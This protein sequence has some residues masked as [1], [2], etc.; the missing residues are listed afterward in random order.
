L[1]ESKRTGET[2]MRYTPPTEV[3]RTGIVI[4]GAYLPRLRPEHAQGF[5]G[6]YRKRDT[7]VLRWVV[8]ALLAALVVAGL[9]GCSDPGSLRVAATEDASPVQLF[10][11]DEYGV[12]C[13]ARNTISLKTLSCVKV[14]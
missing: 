13:Y 10:G 9:A 14:K 8:G 12:V 2:D 4:G 6:P 5:T 3:T 11:P 7:A 1:P